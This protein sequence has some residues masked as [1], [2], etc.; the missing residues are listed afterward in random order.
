MSR[1]AMRACAR[2]AWRQARRAPGRSALIVAMIAFPIAA[3]S[4]G[5]TLI[6]T[7]VP[8]LEEHVTGEMGSAELVVHPSTPGDVDTAPLEALLPQGS[9]VV[10]VHQWQHTEVVNGSLVYATVWETSIP[11]DRPPVPGLYVLMDGRAPTYAG[12]AAV[13]P[14]V[15][16]VY[17]VSIGDDF[18]IGSRTFHIVGIAARPSQMWDPTVVVAPGT[19]RRAALGKPDDVYVVKVLVDLPKDADLNSAKAALAKYVVGSSVR[20]RSKDA[21]DAEDVIASREESA[22][23]FINDA[24]V[25]TGVSFAGTVLA[26]F[27]TGLI[28]A[29]AFAVGIRR[30]LRMV[31]LIGATGGDAAHVRA[32]V[33]MGGMSLGIVGAGVGVVAGVA[34]AFAVTPHLPRFIHALPGAVALHAPTLLGAAFLGVIAATLSAVWPAR[35]AAHLSTL[36]ALAVRLPPSKPPGRLAGRGLIVSAI[37][38]AVTAAGVIRKDDVMPAAGS[39][40]I[41]GGFLVAIPLLMDVA[42]RLTPHMPMAARLA[43]R[44]TARH[45]RRTATAIAAAAVA[46]LVPVGVGALSLSEEA[47]QARY[48]W[49]GEDHMLI[50]STGAQTAPSAMVSKIRKALPGAIIAPIDFAAWDPKVHPTPSDG[51]PAW[52]ERQVFWVDQRGHLSVAGWESASLFIG[53]AD[54]LRALH[55]QDGIGALETGK[56]VGI[57]PG[58][59]ERGV[60]RLALPPV[61]GSE[62]KRIEIA[63]VAAGPI[64]YGFR[65]QV[66]GYVVSAQAARKI[67][68]IGGASSPISRSF[69]TIVAAP[70][71]LTKKQI[72][73]V[74]D[75]A[76]EHP[77]MFVQTVADFLPQFGTARAA[78]T[79]GAAFIALAI[80]AITVAL[81]ASESRRDQAIMVAVGAPPRTRRRIAGARA[82]LIAVLASAIAVPAGF[83]SVAVVQ[84]SRSDLAILSRCAKCSAHFPIIVPAAAIMVVLFAVPVIAATW[85]WLTSR[86]PRGNAMLQPLV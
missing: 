42:G 70:G 74:K 58:S 33:L 54:L 63:A 59:V 53:D 1:S 46:L 41:V 17:R 38:A 30:Q 39:V 64:S 10:A 51:Y 78:A 5:A 56:I 25:L 84:F 66:P 36:D 15:L 22:S 79:A 83:L 52:V 76:S 77:G 16:D 50:G 12:E 11:I 21:P 27:A 24:P 49:I 45:G 40:L 9:H 71:P 73:E 72:R 6:R 19:L 31:G 37:G 69:Q 62:A 60:V 67:G 29:A 35:I 43:V 81:V 86:R 3:L 18:A 34:G 7:A 26:L 20:V 75:I 82:G 4:L 80:V 68:L 48:Q 47:H 13:D 65:E 55:A 8:T 85:G 14:R 28:A 44:D 2:I 32:M 23:S 61:D 57:G